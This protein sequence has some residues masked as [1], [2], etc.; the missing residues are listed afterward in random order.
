KDLE[1]IVSAAQRAAALTRQLLAFGRKQT[2][3]PVALSLNEVVSQLLPMLRRLIPENVAIRVMLEPTLSAVIAD[4]IHL[5]QIL[6]NLVVNARDAMP[7]GGTIT[8]ATR[9]ASDDDYVAGGDVSPGAPGHVV[10]SVADTG[11]GMTREVMARIFE[12]FFTT[13]ERGRGTGL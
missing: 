13:K 12:P 7:Q 3:R 6:M 1:E 9:H 4:A 8:I 5:D 10:L 2:L 11:V